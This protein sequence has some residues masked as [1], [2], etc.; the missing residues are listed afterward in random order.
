MLFSATQTKKV[1]DLAR[2]SLRDP[3]YISVH[4]ES[5]TATPTTL[6]QSVMIVPVEKK[7]DMLWSFI[8]THLND[9]ILVFLSTKKQVL[10][11]FITL[12][13]IFVH[14][15]FVFILRLMKMLSLC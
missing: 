14:F 15:A 13:D 2:L 7:L 4:A 9:R 6:S 1:K 8:R 10:P 5:V 3:E 11:L 12:E